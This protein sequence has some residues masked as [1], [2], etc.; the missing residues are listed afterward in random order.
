MNH[1]ELIAELLA[2]YAQTHYRQSGNLE[3]VDYES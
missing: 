1:F 3:G 2:Q